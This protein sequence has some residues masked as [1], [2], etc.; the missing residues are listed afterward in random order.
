MINKL[1]RIPAFFRE[2]ND[3]LKKVNW[4]SRQELISAAWL[5][6]IVSVILTVY[7]FAVDIGMSNLIQLIL[8]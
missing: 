1:K 2:V 5:V 3:E 7:I 6:V 4:S 8:K